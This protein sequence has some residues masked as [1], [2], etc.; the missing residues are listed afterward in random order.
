MPVGGSVELRCEATG[1][2][3]PTV[4]LLKNIFD[5]S[6]HNLDA[7]NGTIERKV[8]RIDSASPSDAGVYVCLA[9][10]VLVGLP[11]GK[12]KITDWKSFTLEVN[13]R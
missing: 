8:K 4:L 2:P 10:N 13:G 1:S 9:S 5:S 12:R 3:A 11:E 7:G 6:R